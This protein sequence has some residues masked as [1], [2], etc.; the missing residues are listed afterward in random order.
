[1]RKH[2]SFTPSRDVPKSDVRSTTRKGQGLS[3]RSK[4]HRVGP[5]HQELDVSPRG[6]VPQPHALVLGGRDQG[7][8]IG[9]KSDGGDRRRMGWKRAPAAVLAEPPEVA[10]LETAQVFLPGLGQVPF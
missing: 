4:R 5:R 8:P 3:L 2:G 10:P 7:L 1:M 6:Y 9:R